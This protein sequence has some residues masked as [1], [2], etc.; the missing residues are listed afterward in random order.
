MTDVET[1][2]WYDPGFLSQLMGASTPISLG[3]GEKKTQDLRVA[4]GGQ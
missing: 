4:G 1:G 2:E 3:A